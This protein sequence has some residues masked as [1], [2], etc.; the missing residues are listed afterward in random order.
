MLRRQFHAL[1]AAAHGVRVVEAYPLGP[2]PLRPSPSRSWRWRPGDGPNFFLVGAAKS[3]TTAL[4]HALG[5]RDDVYLPAVKEPHYYAYLAD[6]STGSHLFSDQAIARRAYCERY[7][8]VAGQRA[9][10]DGSTTSL[11]VKGAAAA[12]SRDVPSARI[13]AILRQP[14][15]RAFSHFCHFRAA[16]GEEI[17]D[18]ALAVRR[19]GER[20]AAGYPFT[21]QYR[22]WSRYADQLP[23][24][25]ELFGRDCKLSSTC[26]TTCSS[27]PKASSAGRWSSSAPTTGPWWH[28]SGGTTRPPIVRSPGVAPSLRRRVRRI[29]PP[30]VTR[31]LAAWRSRHRGVRPTLDP[32]VRA[33]LTATVEDDLSRLEDLVQRDPHRVATP[34]VTGDGTG[35]GPQLPRRARPLPIE[36]AS[37]LVLDLRPEAPSAN[38]GLRPAAHRSGR[39]C[40]ARL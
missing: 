16:G 1:S 5:Q 27:T 40:T 26:T 20:Q 33:E 17:A 21:Y 2:R 22:G 3:G 30:Q 36:I 29:M 37:G 35:A 38:E 4:Y 34:C 23:P 8:G 10:G 24:F 32:G 13:V 39:V 15:D 18:F 14:V 11:V 25:Y 19:E 9:V 6:P 28:P 31:P 12:I 7:A